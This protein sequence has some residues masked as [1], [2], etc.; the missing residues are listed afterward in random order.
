M[1]SILQV[2]TQMFSLSALNPKCHTV[3]ETDERKNFKPT[4][5]NWSY[6]K[7]V[8]FMVKKV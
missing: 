8:K 1:F 2:Y 6:I 3:Y 5:E 7:M 4:I